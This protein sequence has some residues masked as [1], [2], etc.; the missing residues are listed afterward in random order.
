MKLGTLPE[1]RR[2]PGAGEIIPPG[3][4]GLPRGG[5]E[6]SRAARREEPAAGHAR[7]RI[8]RALGEALAP[9][10]T[11]ARS[12][13]ASIDSTVREHVS[14]VTPWGERSACI[15]EPG[16]PCR[17]SGRCRERGY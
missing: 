14:P 8:A 16:K 3:W 4:V 7:D 12:V 17:G 10:V 13:I 5:R 11:P 1:G 2:S 15:I 6:T 9:G